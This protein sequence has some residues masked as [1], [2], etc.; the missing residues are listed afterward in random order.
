MATQH[1]TIPLANPT[2]D[3]KGDL[4]YISQNVKCQCIRPGNTPL[5]KRAD[6]RLIL[7]RWGGGGART[8][9]SGKPRKRCRF[10]ARWPVSECGTRHNQGT[11]VRSHEV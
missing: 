2:I 8:Y 9:G 5:L 6:R 4:T 10:A 11:F 7:P 1:T 3:P